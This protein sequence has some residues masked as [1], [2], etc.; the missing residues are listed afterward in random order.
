MLESKVCVGWDWF[1]YIDNDPEAKGVDPSNV[2]SNK[3]IVSNRYEPYRPLLE[4]MQQI[5]E[6]VYGITGRPRSKTTA[7]SSAGR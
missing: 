4:A 3:G 6:R 5:N 7:S 2:D 1:K